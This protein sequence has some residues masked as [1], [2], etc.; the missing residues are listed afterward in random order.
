MQ[1]LKRRIKKSI[2]QLRERRVNSYVYKHF[3]FVHSLHLLSQSTL[4]IS[5]ISAQSYLIRIL[6]EYLQ[7]F[8]TDVYHL[9]GEKKRLF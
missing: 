6:R 1:K 2:R 3:K 5:Q 7:N 4:L 8:S 9:Q